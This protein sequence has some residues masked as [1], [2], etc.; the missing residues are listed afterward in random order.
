MIADNYIESL[1]RLLVSICIFLNV[2]VV[3]SIIFKFPFFQI[4]LADAVNFSK[5]DIEYI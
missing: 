4:A 3:T 2:L 5:T 1:I